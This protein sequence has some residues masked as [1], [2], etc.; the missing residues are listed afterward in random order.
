MPSREHN[1]NL[2]SASLHL[3]ADSF[4]SVAAVA[5]GV[6]DLVARVV[7][8]RSCG[9]HRRRGNDRRQQLA[10][11][12]GGGGDSPGVHSPAYRRG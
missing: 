3:L 4:G 2:R 5:A 7:L 8:V 10:A 11:G 6:A 9:R 1:L 12:V